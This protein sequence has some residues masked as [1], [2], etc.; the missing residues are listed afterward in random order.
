MDIGVAG[1]HLYFGATAA[2][3]TVQFGVTFGLSSSTDFPS[4]A[5]SGQSRSSPYNT[6][7][8]IL[9][10]A[11]GTSPET[12]DRHGDYASLSVDFTDRDLPYWGVQEDQTTELWNTHIFSAG[13]Y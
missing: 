7:D 4:V 3:R 13:V 2:D 6:I 10:I 5:F 11:P 9:I 1:K 12:T 8:G